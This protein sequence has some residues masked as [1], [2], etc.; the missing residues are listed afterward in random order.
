MHYP[1]ALMAVIGLVDMMRHP[2][3]LRLPGTRRLMLLFAAI[4]LPMLAAFPDAV[5]SDRTAKTLLLYLH[6]FPAAWYLVIVC[7]RPA[8]YRLVTTGV[9]SLVLF[10]TF[11]AFAQLIWGSNLFGYPYEGTILKGVFH[12]KQRLG[13]FLAVFAPMALDLVRRWSVTMPPVW[14]TLVPYL[15]VMLMSLKRSAW[16]MLVVGIV[17][18]VGLRYRVTHTARLRARILQMALLAAVVAATVMSSGPL[19][20]QMMITA[21]VFSTDAAQFDRAT[22]YRLT[23]WR[24]GYDMFVDN[25]FNGVGPRGY[26]KAYPEYAADNDF[27]IARGTGGSTH[28]HL[29]ALE[30][31]TETGVIGLAG[32]LAFYVVLWSTLVRERHAQIPPLWLLSA[33]VAWLPFNAHLAFYGSYWSSFAWIL[34]GIGLAAPAPGLRTQ[35]RFR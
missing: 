28:P 16:I 3:H 2:E 31:A 18:Y 21:G 34:I 6:L 17:V 1:V 5:N 19:K 32:L 9:V 27:W 25:W 11:D 30:V 20:R 35:P 15:I 33:A 23:L 22:S 24:T 7:A 29:L 8:V 14:L 12:P 4:W 10:V 13:L 26:R